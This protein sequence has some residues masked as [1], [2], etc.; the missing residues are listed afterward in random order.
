[1]ERQRH[2]EPDA[3]A[4][5]A[6]TDDR[7]HEPRRRLLQRCHVDAP[8]ARPVEL[9]EED[10]LPGPERKPAA[11][12][13]NEDLRAHQRSADVRRRILLALLDV[14]PAPAVADDPLE[15]GLEVARDSRVG[16]LVDRH[17]G[18]RVRHV[19]ERRRRAVGVAERLLHLGR[20]VDE[21]G[22]PLG[23]QADATHASL[24]YETV[25]SA[26]LSQR[27]LDA[28][29]EQADRFIAELDEEYYLHYAGLKES[30]EL[31]PIYE[32]HADLTRVE[33]AQSLGAAVNGGG[34]IRELWRFACEGYLGN[35]TREHEERA[36]MLEAEL[37]VTLDGETIPYRMIRPVMANEPE[38]SRRQELDRLRTG[39]VA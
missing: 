33:K 26:P 10:P 3:A 17:P 25:P 16:V 12:E 32:R 24:S 29:R 34:G 14:L 36:A 39:I 37:Q 7:R 6:P 19:D 18:G 31:V 22:L 1:A 4:Q 2:L 38:R 20:D 11:V 28:Y 23:L 15:R 35:L 8:L 27:D 9:A 5:A 21:L 30:F 13:R